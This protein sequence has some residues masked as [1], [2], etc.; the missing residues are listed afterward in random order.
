[1]QESDFSIRAG[2]PRALT[3][4]LAEG[5][6]AARRAFEAAMPMRTIDVAAIEAAVRG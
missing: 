2:T 5:G 1:M 6:D 4:A 3:G